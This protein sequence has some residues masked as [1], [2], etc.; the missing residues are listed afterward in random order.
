MVPAIFRFVPH[1]PR[2]HYFN[3]AVDLEAGTVAA[4][5]ALAAART[6]AHELNVFETDDFAAAFVA[7]NKRGP[8]QVTLLPAGS[9]QSAANPDVEYVFT[10]AQ[11]P[12]GHVRVFAEAVFFDAARS[13]WRA[14]DLWNA[15]LKR[16]E[17]RTT[18]VA[19]RSIGPATRG[20]ANQTLQP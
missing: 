19:P 17:D 10:V 14:T 7:A 18:W 16:I 15:P 2:G 4:A 9:W 3:I 6:L 8:G 12:T 13:E 5:E 1:G 11:M 20:A